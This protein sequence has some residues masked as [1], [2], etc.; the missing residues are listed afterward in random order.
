M[1]VNLLLINQHVQTIVQAAQ[2]VFQK[3]KR[4]LFVIYEISRY[5]SSYMYMYCGCVHVK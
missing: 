1:R 3:K 2:H 4:S 5:I